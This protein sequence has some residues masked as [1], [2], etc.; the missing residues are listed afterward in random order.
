MSSLTGSLEN[1]DLFQ[2]LGKL[3][4]DKVSSLKQIGV[5]PL[6]FSF[7]HSEALDVSANLLIGEIPTS[8]STVTS[9]RELGL[10]QNFLFGTIPSEMGLLTNLVTLR[11]D[12]NFLE[13]DVPAEIVNLPS[14]EILNITGN[15]NLTLPGR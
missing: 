12:L 5:H 8:I 15:S 2:S 6:P 7:T 13:G 1:I 10:K 14:L 11:L 9:L 4:A 3:F